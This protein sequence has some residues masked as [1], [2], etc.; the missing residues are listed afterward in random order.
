[1]IRGWFDVEARRGG[2]DGGGKESEPGLS[3]LSPG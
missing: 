1:M 3:L 2:E